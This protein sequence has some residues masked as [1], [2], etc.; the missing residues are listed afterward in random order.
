MKMH[1]VFTLESAKN[2]NKKIRFAVAKKQIT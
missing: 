1:D 2:Y